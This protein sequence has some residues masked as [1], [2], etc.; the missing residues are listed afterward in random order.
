MPSMCAADARLPAIDA[1]FVSVATQEPVRLRR[2]PH[3]LAG[4]YVPWRYH[5]RHAATG[6]QRFAE[7][8]EEHFVQSTLAP[9]TAPVSTPCSLMSSGIASSCMWRPQLPL[10][11][12]PAYPPPP[13]PPPVTAASCTENSACPSGSG[14]EPSSATSRAVHKR[15]RGLLVEGLIAALR[16]RVSLALGLHCSGPRVGKCFTNVREP[17]FDIGFYVATIIRYA[18]L[19]DQ[20]IVIAVVY[21]DRILCDRGFTLN[22]LN[23]HRLTLTSL[24]MATKYQDGY[25]GAVH[26]SKFW[27]EV[28]GLDVAE[29]VAMEIEFARLLNW[30]FYVCPEEYESYRGFLG[31]GA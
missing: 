25:D 6:N 7:N 18:R 14:D 30:A 4:G 20:A 16:H 31:R 27:A 21:I 12:V 3:S 5:E 9:E 11:P 2:R 8:M 23:V 24:I 10:P 19:S 29:I 15:L 28:N 1:V 26:G 17:S 13:P 22:A